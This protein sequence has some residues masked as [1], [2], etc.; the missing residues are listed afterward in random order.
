MENS[1]FECTI[2]APFEVIWDVLKEEIEQP[3]AFNPGIKGVKILERFNGGVLRSVAVPDADVR[4]KVLYDIN[5]KTITSNLV[6]HPQLFGVIQK[7]LRPVAEGRDDAFT[8]AAWV[9]W[10]SKDDRVFG[11]I[12]RNIEG[13]IMNGLKQVKTKAEQTKA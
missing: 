1:R 4:E 2:N 10:E 8:L 9:E 5:K 11:M 6:G 3:Q 13:F 7:T 12:K